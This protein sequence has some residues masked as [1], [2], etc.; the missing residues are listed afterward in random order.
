MNRLLS[1][2]ILFFICAGTFSQPVPAADENIPYL[3]TFGGN[4]ETSWGDDDFCQIFFCVI[5]KSFND[6]VYIRIYDPDTGGALDELKGDFNSVVSFSVYG[7]TG[8]LVRY[9]SSE[10]PAKREL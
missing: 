9:C 3:M 10:H 7:G 8:M 1:I 6:P 2:L 4:G 5:P